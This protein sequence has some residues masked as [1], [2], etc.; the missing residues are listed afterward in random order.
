MTPAQAD[1]AG[2]VFASS[3]L[4]RHEWKK[5]G[6]CTG[7]S[8]GDYVEAAREAVSSV[9]IPKRFVKPHADTRVSALEVAEAFV[10]VNPHLTRKMIRVSCFHGKLQEVRVCFAKDLSLAE[11]DASLRG[12]SLS[13]VIMDSVDGSGGGQD[14]TSFSEMWELVGKTLGTSFAVLVAAGAII[15]WRWWDWWRRAGSFTIRS[16]EGQP[17]LS[18][19]AH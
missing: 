3:A 11:C 5:H 2:Q 8:V 16:P 18:S 12:C 15:L 14:L 1:S 19:Q 17:L 10:S 13:S 9:H 6:T 7:L 4:A